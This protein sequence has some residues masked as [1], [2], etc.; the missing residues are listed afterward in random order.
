SQPASTSFCFSINPMTAP[1]SPCGGQNHLNTSPTRFAAAKAV[2]QDGRKPAA[3]RFGFSSQTDNDTAVTPQGLAVQ[4]VVT[5]PVRQ[6][7][8]QA[9]S[10]FGL[11]R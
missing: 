7:E 11:R 9:V 6:D 3:R 4:I 10:P 2:R 1:A 8:P 5:D